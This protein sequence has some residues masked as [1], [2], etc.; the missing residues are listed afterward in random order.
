[1]KVYPEIQTTSKNKTKKY[2]NQYLKKTKIVYV[3]YNPIRYN[4]YPI[5]DREISLIECL[6]KIDSSVKLKFGCGD[7]GDG[8]LAGLR[9]SNHEVINFHF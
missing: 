6:E 2:I 8:F 1:M 4:P 7:V 5:E 3:K 9:L